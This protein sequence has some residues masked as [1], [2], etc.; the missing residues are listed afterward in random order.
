MAS[1]RFRATPAGLIS[2]Q[3]NMTCSVLYIR[4]SPCRGQSYHTLS[5][6][7]YLPLSAQRG[8]VTIFND[9][10]LFKPSTSVVGLVGAVS[11]A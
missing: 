5:V 1:G 3:T 6:Q 2:Y 8:M 4:T 10:D 9:P 11:R 7:E